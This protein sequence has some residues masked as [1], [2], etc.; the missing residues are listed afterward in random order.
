MTALLHQNTNFND[1][2]DD[3]NANA[4]L[5]VS[6]RATNCDK[7]NRIKAKTKYM[8]YRLL[9]DILCN[10]Y[11]DFLLCRRSSAEYYIMILQKILFKKSKFLKLDMIHDPS[12]TGLFTTRQARH[13]V[14]GHGLAVVRY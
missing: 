2:P 8:L 14:R 12:G 11:S 7:T 4:I 5:A 3:Q 6:R 10:Y 9:Q 13:L 1:N